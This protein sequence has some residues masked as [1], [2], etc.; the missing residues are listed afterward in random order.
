VDI[1]E[2]FLSRPV[3]S[4][5]KALTGLDLDR[6]Y[7]AKKQEFT[8]PSYKL[9]SDEE[10]REEV[11]K[12]IRRAEYKIQMPPVLRKRLPCEKV[13]RRDPEIQGLHESR[14][15][16][17][18]VSFGYADRARPVVVREADGTLRTATWEERERML[19]TYF[20]NKAREPDTPAMFTEPYLTNV[21]NK[22]CYI[23]VLDRACIQFEPDGGPYLA[24][25]QRVFEHLLESREFDVLRS[26]RHFGPMCFY[27]A[28]SRQGDALMLDMIRRNRMD[29]AVA[30]VKLLHLVH[31][32][33]PSLK[34]V[35]E[36]S[37]PLH[38]AEAYIKFEA[39]KKAALELA[40]QAYKET[41]AEGRAAKANM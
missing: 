8:V 10:L 1:E 29:D 22:H 13:L 24:V 4:L 17:T 21:L 35:K 19:Q 36:D 37:S 6:I 33:S 40:L 18:D 12:A 9:L 25:T 27:Y 31:P 32:D 26:T 2:L 34:A 39:G 7:A 20:T 5:L 15:I 3:Q 14:H 38:Y 41:T 28:V 23:F 30:Y 16:F 11:M